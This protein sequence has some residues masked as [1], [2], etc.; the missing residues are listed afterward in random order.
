MT[1]EWNESTVAVSPPSETPPSPPGGIDYPVRYWVD[2]PEGPRSRLT[3][4]FRG[5]MTMPIIALLAMLTSSNQSW[6]GLAPL[7]ALMLMILVRGKYPRPWFNWWVYLVQFSARV[8]AYFM[9][10]RDEYP[11]TDDE[12]GVHL[13]MDYPADDSLN[14]V[15]PFMKWFLAIP[16]YVV[17]L[18][19]GIASIG[20]LVAMWCSIMFK[21]TTSQRFFDLVVAVNAWGFRVQGYAFTLVTDRYPPFKLGY[22]VSGGTVAVAVVIAVVFYAVIF[23]TFFALFIGPLDPGAYEPASGF[24]TP[25]GGGFR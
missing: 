16:H 13:V 3:V 14:R 12:Q 7:L 19:L 2:F 11:S 18:L 8:T 5:L 17:I 4:F 21:G 24:P 10:L 22:G 25:R 6:V 20:G 9:T 23:G 1:S 15:L